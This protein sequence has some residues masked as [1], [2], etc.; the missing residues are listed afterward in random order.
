MIVQS[1]LGFS[2]HTGCK[3][4]GEPSILTQYIA[5]I[6]SRCHRAPVEVAIIVN[7]RKMR[8][9]ISQGDEFLKVCHIVVSQNASC[10]TAPQCLIELNARGQLIQ[11]SSMQECG[12]KILDK[13]LA[14]KNR[15]HVISMDERRAGFNP[16]VVRDVTAKQHGSTT[17]LLAEVMQ[18]TKTLHLPQQ[19]IV[20]IL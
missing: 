11:Q 1:E 13:A 19:I 4:D 20:E 10:P 6:S 12:Q 3:L 5:R 18:V 14:E 8:E 7:V 15:C 16:G 2:H 9:W 17:I